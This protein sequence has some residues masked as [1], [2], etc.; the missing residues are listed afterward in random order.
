MKKQYPCLKCGNLV[1]RSDAR[2]SIRPHVYCSKACLKAKTES[3]CFN[4]S[5]A[6][7]RKESHKG[8]HVFCSLECFIKRIK[9]VA[10]KQ[11]SG[12]QSPY[13]KGGTLR[14]GYLFVKHPDHPNARKD[15]Y[16][17]LHRLAMSEFLRRPL[18]RKEIVHHK[19]G[20]PLDNRIENL[21]LTTNGEHG[22]IHRATELRGWRKYIDGCS[23]CKTKERR[24]YGHGLCVR[25]Y[26]RERARAQSQH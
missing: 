22:R 23:L 1:Y 3:Q 19:N 2:L 5:K 26:M 20:D 21:E 24:H 17:A 7:H 16:V 8:K 12:M 9:E 6:V 4:C 11:P 25:C 15:G 14:D 13:W 10:A 18:T